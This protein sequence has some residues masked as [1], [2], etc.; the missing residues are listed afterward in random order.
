MEGL[1]VNEKTLR[2][3]GTVGV[4][5]QSGIARNDDIPPGG[6]E[7]SVGASVRQR[8]IF[9]DHIIDRAVIPHARGKRCNGPRLYG[10]EALHRED[11]AAV[12]DLNFG[13]AI[14]NRFNKWAVCRIEAA[15]SV[16]HD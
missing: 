7:E 14:Q 1:V 2:R 13:D 3:I 8:R 12:V 11:G 10:W 6:Y 9:V 15:V 16:G 5:A 4:S